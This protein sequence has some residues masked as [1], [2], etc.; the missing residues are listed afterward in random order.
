MGDPTGGTRTL[1]FGTVYGILKASCSFFNSF[2]TFNSRVGYLVG[3]AIFWSVSEEFGNF[4]QI[5]CKRGNR[6]Q[7]VEDH[8]DEDLDEDVDDLDENLDEIVDDFDL[9][10][11]HGGRLKL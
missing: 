4:G 7:Q 8:L 3:P 10:F 5:I 6:H 2:N 1:N 9:V 11:H